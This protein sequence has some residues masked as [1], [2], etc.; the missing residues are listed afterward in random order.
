[1]VRRRHPRRRHDGRLLGES[2]QAGDGHVLL[3]SADSDGSLA[4]IGAVAFKPNARIFQKPVA[5]PEFDKMEFLG[6]H[7]R[8]FGQG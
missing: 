3:V 8:D 7:S 6:R 2:H 4:G 1:M 5:N